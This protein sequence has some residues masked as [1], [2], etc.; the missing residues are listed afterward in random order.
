MVA[1]KNKSKKN[2]I[3]DS[4]KVS[5]TVDSGIL[6]RLGLELF[7]R[8]ESAVAELIKNAYD[9]DANDVKVTFLDVDEKGGTLIID[10]DGEG[11]T[12]DQI[13]NGFMRIASTEK[14]HN[15]KT[16]KGRKKA[17][18]KGIGR[19]ATIL[20]GSKITIVTNNNIEEDFAYKL[21]IDW[22]KY[23]IDSKISTVENT[24]E[25]IE[26]TK[27]KGTTL[28]IH[29]LRESWSEKDIRRVYR[30]IADLLQP[31]LYEINHRKYSKKR[32]IEVKDT[33]TFEV[34]FYDRENE[35]PLADINIMMYDKA[36]AK[37]TAYI[38][39]DGYGYCSINSDK[40]GLSGKEFLKISDTDKDREK[41]A[42]FDD[43]KGTNVILI[44]YYFIGNRIEYYQDSF[45]NPELTAIMNY[46][47]RD[48]GVKLYRNRFRLPNYGGN[49]DWLSINKKSRAFDGFPF[50]TKNFTGYVQL[51][52]QKDVI[53]TKFT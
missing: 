18:K 30:Y 34:R 14:L 44:A 51:T 35:E 13:I 31:T 49:N 21:E 36:L 4:E 33:D 2:K 15:P 16:T 32:L 42:P 29:H 43:L 7:Q 3:G 45:T 39:E 6:Y 38:D 41:H 22:N 9:A 11:M 26:K 1:E 46:L 53:F 10:D 40:F 27:P 37:I 28:T 25:I 19:I 5:F 47:K 52:D 48:G 24:L 50:S 12:K 23:K 17:G 20:L 8:A